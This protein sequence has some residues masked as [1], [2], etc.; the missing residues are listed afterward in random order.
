MEEGGWTPWI[1]GTVNE[2]LCGFI[3]KG[4]SDYCMVV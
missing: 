3:E 4:E 2:K 1:P